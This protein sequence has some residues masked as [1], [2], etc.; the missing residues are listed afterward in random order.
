MDARLPTREGPAVGLPQRRAMQPK[1]NTLQLIEATS[2][3]FEGQV[4]VGDALEFLRDQENGTADLLFLDPPFN[5]GKAYGKDSTIDNKTPV[6]YEAWMVEILGESVRLLAD[7]G[8]LYLYHVPFWAMKLGAYLADSLDLRHW[9][10]VAMKNNFVRGKR[11]Y[12]AHYSLLYFTKGEPSSFRRPKL[13]PQKCRHCNEPVKDYG[14]YWPI[15]QA[16][17]L[18]LSDFWDDISPV[19]HANRKYREQ[20]ELPL[21][22]TERIVQISGVPGALFVDPFAG[23]GAGV[24]AAAKAGLRFKAC[25]LLKANCEIIQKRL[26]HV[27]RKTPPEDR[28]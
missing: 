25:D 12:P 23:T 10:A 17:G 24:I 6:E 28:I 16:K 9:I 27:S 15:V 11:L 13:A 26:I 3:D 19:R 20:N 4:Y 2:P 1:A 21:K 14:G 22:L 5:L 7:G 8:A 18:N